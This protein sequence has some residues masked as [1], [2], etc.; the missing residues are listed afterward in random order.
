MAGPSWL[1]HQTFHLPTCRLLPL[2]PLLRPQLLQ[3][4]VPNLVGPHGWLDKA[5]CIERAQVERCGA[6]PQATQEQTIVYKLLK[7]AVIGAGHLTNTKTQRRFDR[8]S[9]DKS[10]GIA[11]FRFCGVS[12]ISDVASGTSVSKRRD[13]NFGITDFRTFWR[14]LLRMAIRVH[15]LPSES[16]FRFMGQDTLRWKSGEYR[17]EIDASILRYT[18]TFQ[19][20]WTMF[21]VVP[22]KVVVGYFQ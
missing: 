11:Q 18:P 21:R 10:R 4:V 2:L 6:S 16:N 7:P 5:E 1:R 19:T 15:R 14:P 8:K 9:H 3:V 20:P 22:H 12:D 17:A 13:I